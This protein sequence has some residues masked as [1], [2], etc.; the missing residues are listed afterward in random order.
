MSVWHNTGLV[1]GFW[2]SGC[3]VS[4]NVMSIIWPPGLHRVN[5]STKI[6]GC[7]VVRPKKSC[8]C[9]APPTPVLTANTNPVIKN[10][11]T[12][13]ALSW[14]RWWTK[15]SKCHPKIKGFWCEKISSIRCCV[16]LQQINPHMCAI[17]KN[18]TCD[19]ILLYWSYLASIFEEKIASVRKISWFLKFL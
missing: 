11:L 4:S 8:G 12:A 1:L 18:I 3:Q 5:W 19:I 17:F 15:T 7:Q 9:Q 13:K 14:V 16:K 6:Y 10:I 2:S